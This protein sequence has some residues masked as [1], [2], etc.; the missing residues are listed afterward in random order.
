M[1]IR[2]SKPCE[3]RNVEYIYSSKPPLVSEHAF[4]PMGFAV[5]FTGR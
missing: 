2:N 4:Q 1:Q 3:A 5:A